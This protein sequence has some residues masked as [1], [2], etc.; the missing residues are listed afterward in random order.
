MIIGNASMRELHSRELVMYVESTSI[1]TM[2]M[3]TCSSEHMSNKVSYFHLFL[4]KKSRI[5]ITRTTRPPT[6]DEKY[7]RV[8]PAVASFAGTSSQ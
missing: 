5:I 2:F 4:Y 7:N 8:R 3:S 6:N 1:L